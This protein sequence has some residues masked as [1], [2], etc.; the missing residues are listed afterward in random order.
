MYKLKKRGNNLNISKKSP[1]Q[2]VSPIAKYPF[3]LLV[4]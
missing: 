3:E 4:D 1:N 2:I